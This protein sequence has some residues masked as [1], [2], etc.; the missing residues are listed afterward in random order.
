MGV[1]QT[2]HKDMRSWGTIHCSLFLCTFF[3]AL[4]GNTRPQT[5]IPL[6][7]AAGNPFP[8]GG[9]LDTDGKN[10]LPPR[11]RCRRRRGRRARASH[12]RY[13]PAEERARGEIELCLR[14]DGSCSGGIYANWI[15]INGVILTTVMLFRD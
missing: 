5:R 12:V 11:R 14:R 4:T 15:M 8:V 6:T 2:L 9:R 1:I 7:A 10:G 13:F 3:A